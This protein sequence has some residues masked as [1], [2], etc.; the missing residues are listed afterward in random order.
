MV[1]SDVARTATDIDAMNTDSLALAAI[2]VWPVVPLFWIPVHCAT[3]I[4]RRLGFL[5]YL[6]PLITWLPLAYFLYC[7]RYFLLKAKVSFPDTLRVAGALLLCLGTSLHIWTGKLL[8]LWG[9]VGLPEIGARSGGRL[10][11]KGPFS[12]VRHPTY[13]AHT[14]MFFGV[15]LFSGVI[16]VG[17]I[18]LVDLLVINAFVIPLEDK[19]LGERFGDDHRAYRRRVPAFFPRLFG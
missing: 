8:G 9:L 19:E 3:G 12:V 4:F 6:M 5:T 14:M 2:I 7:Q 11:T 13:L 10:I 15:F 1:S 16:A 18:T 17:I